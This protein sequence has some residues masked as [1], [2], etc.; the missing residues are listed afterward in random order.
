MK[1]RAAIYESQMNFIVCYFALHSL[2][3]YWIGSR[4]LFLSF[5]LILIG[6]PIIDTQKNIARS[7]NAAQR[8]SYRLSRSSLSYQK[9][10]LCLAEFQLS[11]FEFLSFVTTLVFGF[12]H[13]LS[14]WVLPQF[15]F[16]SFVAIWFFFSFV[17][18]W[19]VTI[20]VLSLFEF[21]CFFTISV[22]EL[23]HI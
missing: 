20:W 16:L 13:N 1:F 5:D 8:T 7:Q 6:K 14:F 21:L 9:T 15:E 10:V 17:A 19:V 12:Y 2:K 4:Y 3:M 22:L 11:E 23:C 18:I